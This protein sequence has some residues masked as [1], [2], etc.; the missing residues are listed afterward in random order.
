MQR[1]LLAIE[2]STST[3][4][5]ALVS[6]DG[7]VAFHASLTAD[8]HAANLLTMCDGLFKAANTTPTQL[9]AIACGAGPGS[10]TGLRVGMALGKGLAMPF[11]TPFVLQSSLHTLAFDLVAE[12]EAAPGQSVVACLDGGKGELHAQRF[13]C[14]NDGLTASDEPWRLSPA[15][16][17]DRLRLSAAAIHAVGGPRL[18][19]FPALLQGMACSKF[20][21]DVQG[22]SA[23]QLARWAW[24]ALH[25]GNVTDLGAAAPTYGRGPDIT[26]PKRKTVG[27][28]GSS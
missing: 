25:Q 21:P 28:A 23:A 11:A 6:E 22:P 5:V 17:C 8:R 18:N 12:S 24:A 19:K 27:E 7:T 20:L 2:T 26:T 13:V 15:D 10:F 1:M 4:R 3:A 14:S 9:A 16:L